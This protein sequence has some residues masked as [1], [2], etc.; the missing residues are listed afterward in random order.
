MLGLSGTC[1][2]LVDGAGGNL[3]CRPFDS[4][5]SCR[6]S[7]TWSYWRSRLALQACCGITYLQICLVRAVTIGTVGVQLTR[8]APAKPTSHNTKTAS[9]ITTKSESQAA[10]IRGLRP[11]TQPPVT[12]LSPTPVGS[13]VKESALPPSHRLLASS[14]LG[15]ALERLRPPLRHSVAIPQQHWR[16]DRLHE[17]CVPPA[18]RPGG[19]PQRPFRAHRLVP[20]FLLWC[21][22]GV[23][24]I[25]GGPCEMTL[26]PSPGGPR[27]VS[28]SR[29]ATRSIRIS[30]A[31]FVMRH[32]YPDGGRGKRRDKCPTQL[33][34]ADQIR[35]RHLD[36]APVSST[37][38]I[39]CRLSRAVDLI[40][41]RRGLTPCQAMAF[42]R[43]ILGMLLRKC[44]V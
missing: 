15:S 4:P 31:T 28:T 25:A 1:P 19:W 6:L 12:T 32:H 18:P 5:R 21:L 23:R 43:R 11:R 14:S 38:Y 39:P 2:L 16:G 30:E 36:V 24:W 29:S 42:R 8:H 9:N 40:C 13:N 20:R 34:V 22:V 33:S 44:D 41:R 17:H 10:E 37:S 26:V 35:V 3:L 27:T 7:L